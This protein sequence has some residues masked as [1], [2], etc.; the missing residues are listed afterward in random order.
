ME[1]FAHRGIGQAWLA[2]AGVP[3][4]F[5]TLMRTIGVGPGVPAAEIDAHRRLLLGAD[6][7]RAFLRIMRSF[8]RTTD[9][10]RRYEAAVGSGAYP[11][12]L[13]W[14][15]KDPA[16]P[17]RTYGVQARLAARL[18]DIPTVPAKHFLQE[19]VPADIAAAVRELTQRS[20]PDT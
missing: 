16:L 12:G 9:K 3:V 19:Y 2:A 1:P 8:E 6:S 17:L 7:G 4:V 14:G 18:A 13:L 11:V 20:D 15:S 5:R 10:R